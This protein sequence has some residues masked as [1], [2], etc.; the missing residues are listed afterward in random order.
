MGTSG[1]P[2]WMASWRRAG[3]MGQ[4]LSSEVGTKNNCALEL[5]AYQQSPSEWPC[6]VIK[7]S[8]Q[9]QKLGERERREG[10]T[11]KPPGR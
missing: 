11:E 1:H 4:V 6:R 7:E 5:L 9:R 8:G 3:Q 10:Q 2:V